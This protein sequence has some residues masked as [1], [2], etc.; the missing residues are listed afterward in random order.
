MTSSFQSRDS[1]SGAAKSLPKDLQKFLGESS[2]PLKDLDYLYLSR[3]F[4][5]V[6]KMN[7]NPTDEEAILHLLE[8]DSHFLSRS[9]VMDYSI[10]IGIEE[11][12]P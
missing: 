3:N 7:L 10:L 4:S 11:I 1:H 5:D 2:E 9:N 6:F 8:S 12:N